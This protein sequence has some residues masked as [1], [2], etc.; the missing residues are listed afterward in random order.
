MSECNID[1]PVF[2]ALVGISAEIQAAME[3]KD[4]RSLQFIWETV[5]KRLQEMNLKHDVS[6]SLCPPQQT[7]R[8]FAYILIDIT[9]GQQTQIF[10]RDKKTAEQ[11]TK[12]I[13]DF[14][15][16]S[17]N[18]RVKFL[19]GDSPATQEKL[20]IILQDEEK[21][22]AKHRMIAIVQQDNSK[23]WTISFGAEM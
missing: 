20:Q 22:L 14:C 17:I 6:V 21:V 5:S 7:E 18:N 16:T 13:Q 1:D 12:D 23:S 9:G 4:N 11:T 8:G 10:A 19:L 2:I 15:I 3:C